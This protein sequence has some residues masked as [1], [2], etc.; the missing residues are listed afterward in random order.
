M[1]FYTYIQIEWIRIFVIISLILNEFSYGKEQI[2]DTSSFLYARLKN[3][4]IMLYPPASVRPSV[5]PS[6]NFFVSV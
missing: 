5:R 4:R 1:I 2:A 6:V 3:G